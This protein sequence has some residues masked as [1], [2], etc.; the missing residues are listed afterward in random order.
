MCVFGSISSATQS[1]CLSW[2]G[3]TGKKLPEMDT[4]RSN[5]SPCL[6]PLI[7]WHPSTTNTEGPR[8]SLGAVF[9]S[10]IN[11]SKGVLLC[12]QGATSWGFSFQI[13]KK[14]LGLAEK[15]H[16]RQLREYENK[17]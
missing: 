15:C 9:T 11:I 8:E 3:E 7:N 4:V 2:G 14:T 5:P 17:E 13:F 10:A 16:L 12:G 1:Y 6:M